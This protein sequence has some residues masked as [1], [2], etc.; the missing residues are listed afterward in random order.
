MSKKNISVVLSFSIL[1]IVSLLGCK[2]DPTRF[3]FQQDTASYFVYKNNATWIYATNGNTEGDTVVST[4]LATGMADRSEG[5]VEVASVTLLGTKEKKTI[6][7][8][9]VVPTQNVDRIA[10]LHLVDALFIPNPVV[11]NIAGDMNAEDSSKV[12]KL[13]NLSVNGKV[14]SEVLEMNL[15]GNPYFKKVWF[16]KNIGIVR[17][18]YLNNDTFNLVSFREGI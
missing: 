12:T 9:E 6:I 2:Q 3:L 7:R 8:S 16:A 15:K 14:Y 1:A 18:V 5:I 17:K 10:I 13:P 4:D 11:I